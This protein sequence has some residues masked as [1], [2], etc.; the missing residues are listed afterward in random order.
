MVGTGGTTRQA[1]RGMTVLFSGMRGRISGIRFHNGVPIAAARRRPVTSSRRNVVANTQ[2]LDNDRLQV[3]P[4]QHSLQ[5]GSL[6]Q[7]LPFAR[8]AAN[9]VE[10]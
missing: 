4:L 10:A 1:F 2:L 9:E 8:G 3:P 6:P 5:W 7:A